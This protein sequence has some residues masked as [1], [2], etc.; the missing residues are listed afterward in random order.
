MK[1]NLLVAGDSFAEFPRGGTCFKTLEP[2]QNIQG[3]S[4]DLHWCELWAQS[5]GGSARSLGLGGAGNTQA[6]NAAVRGLAQDTY[7]H[8]VY[9]LTEP[10][11]SVKR[12]T[13]HLARGDRT[14]D[15]Y[16]YVERRHTISHNWH[17]SEYQQSIATPPLEDLERLNSNHARLDE[18]VGAPLAWHWIKFAMNL[19]PTFQP[20]QETIANLALLNS[21]CNSRGVKLMVTSGFNWPLT[22]ESWHSTECYPQFTTFNFWDYYK[23]TAWDARSHY[24]ARG[25][26][27][28]FKL[29][30]KRKLD[31][32]LT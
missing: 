4:L 13:D 17:H 29:L 15:K 12:R 2:E 7:T 22:V 11:R 5:Q 8:C 19:T 26:Q 10:S 32:W 27:K 18:T 16:D 14:W 1:P 6:V 30:H 31:S 21:A 25:H 3:C 24:C 20:A 28:I 23:P 9:F